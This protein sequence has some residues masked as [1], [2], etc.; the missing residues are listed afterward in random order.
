MTGNRTYL[1]GYYGHKNIGDDVFCVVADW[2]FKNKFGLRNTHVQGLDL[3]QLKYI[4]SS[5]LSANKYIK[6]GQLYMEALKSSNIIHVGGSTFGD[7]ARSIVDVRNIYQYKKLYALGISVGPFKT[8]ADFNYIKNYLNKFRYVS[9]RD[10]QSMD[11]VQEMKLESKVEKGFDVAALL[12]LIGNDT[13]YVTP[14]ATPASENNRK[15]IGISVCNY[16]KYHNGN[17]QKEQEREQQLL[18][19][20]SSLHEMYSD[21]EFRFFIFNANEH[22]GDKP[23]TE[24]IISQVKTYKK[25]TISLVDYDK[26][27]LAFW[28]NMKKCDLFIGFRLHSAIM[29]Y[30]AEVPFML[31][32]YHTKCTDFLHSVGY[33][34]AYQ[35]ASLTA[36]DKASRNTLLDDLLHKRATLATLPPATATNIVYKNL[37]TCASIIQQR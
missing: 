10:Q 28:D 21:V 2:T 14:E 23:L 17:P 29:S 30:I 16:E 3:P 34:P 12:P 36:Q 26:D 33:N 25:V 27:T 1:R 18:L 20:L 6:Y 8:K 7:G 4:Q 22:V 32:E 37:E 35:V 24:R 11:Y 19:L 13:S 9:V 31:F 5:K 15:I